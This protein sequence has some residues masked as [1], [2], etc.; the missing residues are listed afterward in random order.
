MVWPWSRDPGLSWRDYG[1]E[2]SASSLDLKVKIETNIKQTYFLDILLNLTN[3]S[4]SPFHKENHDPVYINKASNHPPSRNSCP[5]WSLPDCLP[6]SVPRKCSSQKLQSTRTLWKHLDLM[7]NSNLKKTF[8]PTRSAFDPERSFGST[9]HSAKL[10]K[11][12]L[13]QSS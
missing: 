5:V 8:H 6:Y 3:N 4:C 1:R 12:M 2:F 7:R 13:A 11:L 10:W 9:P